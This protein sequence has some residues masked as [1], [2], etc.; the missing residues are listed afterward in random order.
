MSPA[1]ARTNRP[2]GSAR[3]TGTV[4]GTLRA[5]PARAAL[6]AAPARTNGSTGPALPAGAASTGSTRTPAPAVTT[7][8]ARTA[9]ALRPTRSDLPAVLSRPSGYASTSGT[10]RATGTTR[11]AVAL[12][13][14]LTVVRA[15]AAAPS[16]AT[17]ALRPSRA[18]R[19]VVRTRTAG[20]APG[21][22]PLEAARLAE[23]ALRVRAATAAL[24]AGPGP[25]RSLG[26]R[27]TAA[28]G[29]APAARRGLARLRAVLLRLA[30][31]AL[32]HGPPTTAATL[33]TG[34]GVPDRRG[35][36]VHDAG[37]PGIART[38]GRGAD[39]A[40]HSARYTVLRTVRAV[41]RRR[42]T[43][44]A[45]VRA[46][47]VIRHRAAPVST[48]PVRAVHRR[49]AT[50]SRLPGD[51][52]G[53]LRRR[54][55][56]RRTVPRRTTR[57]LDTRRPTGLRRTG[58][59]TAS[60]T[61]T[62]VPRTAVGA[63]IR[64]TIRTVPRRRPRRRNAL[65]GPPGCRRHP[66]GR[67]RSAPAPPRTRT[68]NARTAR[69]CPRSVTGLRG[70]SSASPPPT[71]RTPTT[72]SPATGSPAA[73]SLTTGGPAPGRTALGPDTRRIPGST[74]SRT[75]PAH[76]SGPDQLA[77][78][79]GRHPRRHHSPAG[80]PGTARSR[81]RG[82]RAPRRT[83]PRRCLRAGHHRRLV[84]RVPPAP[85]RVARPRG[86]RR[87][88]GGLYRNLQQ[89]RA[90]ALPRHLV[91]LQ[92]PA[93]QEGDPPRQ[94]LVH[95]TRRTRPA[96]TTRTGSTSSTRSTDP[97]RTLH[98][99]PHHIPAAGRRHHHRRVR[100]PRRPLP[101]GVDPRDL[102]DQVCQRQ[103]QPPP[104]RLDLQLRRVHHE[105]R[106]PGA[107]QLVRTLGRSVHHVLD[108]HRLHHQPLLAG[109]QPLEVEDAVDERGHPP[110]PGGEVPQRL[111]GL[112]PELPGRVVDEG[113]QLRP[114]GV[115]RAAQRDGEHRLQLREPRLQRVAPPPVGEG[116]DGAD[117]LVAVAHRGGRHVHRYRLAVAA[118]QH[119]AA[120]AV[121]APRAQGVRDGGLLVRQGGAVGAGVVDEGVEVGAAEFA[122]A[123]AED[124]RGGGVD[125]DDL[126]GGVRTDDA[127]GGGAQDHLGLPALPVQLRLDLRRAREVPYDEHEQ[128]VARVVVPG[129]V[130]GLAA[131]AV[132]QV[133]AGDLGGE[134]AA[135][136]AAGGHAQGLRT[137]L[138]AHPR[139]GR[140][141]PRGVAAGAAHGTGDELRV[142]VRQQV[143]QPAAHDG[144]A[145]PLEGLQRDAVRGDDG[146]VGVDE[147]QRVGECV[148]YGGEASSASGW[149]AAHDELPPR[150]PF[151]LCS[152]A[153][154]HAVAPVVRA[155]L[156]ARTRP[157]RAG[158]RATRGFYGP[159]L[160]GGR[161]MRI[162]TPP[163]H[164]RRVPPGSGRGRP[165]VVRSADSTGRSYGT[166]GGNGGHGA[167]VRPRALNCPAQAAEYVKNGTG[168]RAPGGRGATIPAAP[169]AAAAP[170]WRRR[171]PAPEARGRTAESAPEAGERTPVRAPVRTPTRTPVR[172]RRA[173]TSAASFPRAATTACAPPS[174]P[175]GL[176]SVGRQFLHRP[177]TRS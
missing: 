26:P 118:P 57:L 148:E 133:R 41:T 102:R 86:P 6:P 143:E 22:L 166:R 55:S 107:D 145:G 141:G 83:P 27:R 18:A 85:R 59:A 28:H 42:H 117:E 15:L 152:A 21:A 134:A 168:G 140:D 123:V 109:V 150:R 96:R 153:G 160:P 89:V 46:L 137:L 108:V 101:R 103:R 71:A 73:G 3:P 104:V 139:V 159:P 127:L 158:G 58:P 94:R 142:E 155:L 112:R 32:A 115:E 81:T 49:R 169:K 98:L 129:R 23:S 63:A 138:G 37:L 149:P 16:G 77:R 147:E 66:R 151:L 156:R 174:A 30:A 62:A 157:V 2:T 128:L 146:A 12:G 121:L 88:P 125:E 78:V 165:G 52:A 95:R 154:P 5:G 176:T 70:G 175:P 105:L 7:G 163:P 56:L 29:A 172:P 100:R 17:A 43:T 50:G 76:A 93:V 40:R 82:P 51:A 38:A 80:R 72:G 61:R 135:V 54:R 124:L 11:A 48:G 75:G 47:P 116:E 13:P 45:V 35:A 39:I 68:A 1:P 110:V 97:P 20:T 114:Q 161:R 106:P 120:Y 132:L 14:A 131:G 64:R 87:R 91:R 8:A 164:L 69:G 74:G 177:D 4:V 171:G 53:R 92:D 99:Y 67:C 44:P 113:V 24:P 34:E 122:G 36:G 84:P 167:R 126:A 130:R 79:A 162:V 25:T 173:P 19:P 31:R 10:P 90:A 60:R 136:G 33:R 111:V 119:L 144:G 65:G 170:P 9:L